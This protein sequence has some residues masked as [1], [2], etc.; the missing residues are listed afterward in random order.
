MIMRGH[1]IKKKEEEEE[2]LK[3][4]MTT[5]PPPTHPRPADQQISPGQTAPVLHPQ[6][7]TIKKK[8]DQPAALESSYGR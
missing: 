6:P 2:K 7:Q 5:T 3:Q 8:K 1:E 4:D